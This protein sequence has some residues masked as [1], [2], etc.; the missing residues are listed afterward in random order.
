MS[1][2]QVPTGCRKGLFQRV[3][4]CSSRIAPLP[5]TALATTQIAAADAGLSASHTGRIHEVS[6]G[7][8]SDIEAG[9]AVANVPMSKSLPQAG[10]SV[11]IPGAAEPETVCRFALRS[12]C[13]LRGLND[14]STKACRLV[15]LS[16]LLLTSSETCCC[17]FHG[18]A[19]AALVL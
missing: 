10:T 17:G 7:D 18:C 13:N 9:L 16:L 3:P 15:E 12:V 5:P 4:D 6:G 8:A 1:T 11:L 19:P 2:V 14:V